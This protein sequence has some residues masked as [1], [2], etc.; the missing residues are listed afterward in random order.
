MQLDILAFTTQAIT[1][2]SQNFIITN[3][4]DRHSVSSDKVHN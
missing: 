2:N 3:I 4:Q 1:L